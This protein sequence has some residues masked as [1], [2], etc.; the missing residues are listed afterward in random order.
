MTLRTSGLTDAII[1]LKSTGIAGLFTAIPRLIAF[2]IQLGT[3]EGWAAVKTMNLSVALKTLNIDPVILAL[4][5]LV[6]V[7]TAAYFAIDALT[8]TTEEYSE[9]LSQSSQELSDINSK[10]SDLNS[11]L[12]TTQER[13]KELE[14][15]DSLTLVEQNELETIF[16]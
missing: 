5:A 6:A 14:A 3:S 4:S 9:K 13:I 7:G 8:T 10:I 2:I 12:E 11:E 15:K 16:Y 1:S